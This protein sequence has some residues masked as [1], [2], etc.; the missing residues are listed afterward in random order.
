[1]LLLPLFEGQKI[2]EAK[3][4]NHSQRAKGVDESPLGGKINKY[5]HV[6]G[7][8]TDSFGHYSRGY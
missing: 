5:L 1:M 4:A 2:V 7:E 6:P 3:N 8:G